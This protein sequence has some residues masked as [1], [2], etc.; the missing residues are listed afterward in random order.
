MA[1]EPDCAP[2]RASAQTP[3][4]P[5]PRRHIG[6]MSPASRDERIADLF[7]R[8]LALAPGDREA[9][10]RAET[11][12]TE[13]TTEVLALLAADAERTQTRFRTPWQALD[14]R[15]TIQDLGP[16]HIVAEIGEGGMGR[17][18]RAEQT[19][20]IRRIVAVKVLKGTATTAMGRARFRVEQQVLARLQ[21]PGI[22]RILD[23][24]HTREGRPFLVMDFVDG[25][26]LHRWLAKAPAGL[27]TRLDLFA[28]L[29]DAVQHA[30][31]KGVIH[32]DLKPS[33][34]LVMTG[35]LG[36]EPCVIDFGI[37]RVLDSSGDD[38]TLHTSGDAALGTLGYM[39]PEQAGSAAAAD[40]RSDVYALGVILYEM[41]TGTRPF[42]DDRPAERWAAAPVRPSQQATRREHPPVPPRE[43]S[44]DLD[45]VVLRAL[46]V[47]PDQRYATVQEFAAD[48]Q[49]AR[50]HEPV[51]ARAPTWTYL[52]ARLLRRHRVAALFVAALLV[53][54]LASLGVVL[55][56]WERAEAN[57]RDYRR[58]VD[59]K[60]L[61]DLRTEARDRLW[62]A[63]PENIAAMDRWR[64]QALALLARRTDLQRRVDELAA[65]Q[66]ASC[67]PEERDELALQA[68]VLQRLLTGL[69]ELEHRQPRLD[70]LAGIAAR[71]A[72]AEATAAQGRAAAT[73]WQRAID[74]IADPHDCPAYGG[75]RLAGPQVGLVP[76]GRDHRSGL[77]EFWHVESGERPA[78]TL[79]AAGRLTAVAIGEAS[80]MVFVLAPGGTFTMGAL[81]EPDEGAGDAP[82][83]PHAAP[84]ERFV[85]RVALA[86][87]F[88]AKH[89]CTQGQ[90]LR[91]TGER[92]SFATPLS[93]SRG[94]RPDLRHPVEQIE[95]STAD[96]E[97]TRRGLA[98]PTEAQWEYCCRAGSR[99]VFACGDDVAALAAHANLA[100]AGSKDYLRSPLEPGLDDGYS[101]TA[102]VGTFAPNAFGLHDCHGNV[103][104]W[105]RDWLVPY[106]RAAATGDGLRAPLP[107]DQATLRVTRGGDFAERALLSRCASRNA[108]PPSQRTARTG[109]RAVRPIRQ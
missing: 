23:G 103:A 73:E 27:A 36:P 28:R 46:A 58:L 43:L 17:V 105:C 62:P 80:G 59:D 42:P 48:V 77:W 91:L 45:L 86:P 34:V 93:K 9:F 21:H 30:H 81:H 49:R 16:Y 106:A 99:T 22:A 29:C 74:S 69:D 33:N 85:H 78:V 98:L 92:P 7:H 2:R 50:R 37:A 47:E 90:W 109:L 6:C 108:A 84:M 94:N 83:D 67:E 104:E 31:G 3:L 100:D 1:E 65:R 66:A 79:D 39:S 25:V 101:L 68:E 97:L 13:V 71:R 8:A 87:F 51:V 88:I 61:L 96:R 32:R 40:A 19:E 44:S 24:G 70:N 52:G 12:D 14:E 72:A 54:L 64:A 82:I 35:D 63:W 15:A 5:A 55:Q 60:R 107:E 26:P 89:E 18:Y 76:L 38:E 11:S 4:H 41:L 75:L 56:Q 95:W 20:P 10:V 57:W 53:V 102:P